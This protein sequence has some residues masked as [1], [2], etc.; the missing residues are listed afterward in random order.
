MN[1]IKHPR[2]TNEGQK[3]AAE[4]SST[5]QIAKNAVHGGPKNVKK[6]RRMGIGR[7]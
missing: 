1:K 2:K 6:D 3:Q 5:K 4:S 7:R